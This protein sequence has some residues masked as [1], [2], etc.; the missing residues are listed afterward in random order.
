VGA[1]TVVIPARLASSR[2]QRKVLLDLFGKTLIE[3]THAVAAAAD[4]G[5]VLVLTDSQEVADVVERFGG[6]AWLT[7]AALP[8]GTARIASVAGRLAGDVV[9]NLQGDAPLTDPAVV[10]QAAHEARSSKAAVTMPVYRIEDPASLAD[11]NI[12]KV[13]RGVDGAALYCSR[14]PIPYVRDAP[15]EEW[16]ERTPFWGHVGLYA[17]SLGFLTDFA[18]LPPSSLEE[19]EKLEQLRWLEAG[20]PVHTF[21][22]EPQGPSVDT[23]EQLEDVRE[24][25]L[26]QVPVR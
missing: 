2:L 4:C 13:V 9:V 5:R 25:L 7:D 26:N 23:A 3:R 12:V 11:P 10:R 18:N 19:A 24:A 14:S 21:V 6:E 1:T 8:S 17:Y 15:H 16:P 22:V 20:L